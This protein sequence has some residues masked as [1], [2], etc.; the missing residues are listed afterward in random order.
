MRYFLLIVCSALL[1]SCSGT[2]QFELLDSARTGIDFNNSISVADSFNILTHEHISNGAGVG[3]GDLNNDGLADIVFAG[4]KVT[5]RIYLNSG[6]FKF[7]DI[8][9]NFEGLINDQWFSGVTIVDLNSDGWQ[10]VYLT[11]TCERNP[12]KCKNRLWI[13]KGKTGQ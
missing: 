1:F 7:K 12:E 2:V 13:N 10:D 11:S 9:S 8:T 4:N 5:P 3:I 6:N